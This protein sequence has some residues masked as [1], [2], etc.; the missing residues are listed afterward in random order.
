MPQV[1]VTGAAGYVGSI[2]VQALKKSG[3]DILGIDNLARGHR[4]AIDEDMTF[5]RVN[6]GDSDAIDRIMQQSPIDAVVHLA[7][8]AQAGES[9]T[10][11]GLY[12]ANNVRD[13]ITLLECM[14][15]NNVA[16]IVFSSSAAVYGVPDR[17]PITEDQA[18][19][20]I[21]PYGQSKAWMEFVL[22]SYAMS[23]DFQVV[24]LRYF[25]AAGAV[26]P[27][28]EDHRPETHL[29]P[30]AIRVA[31]EMDTELAI[32]GDDYPTPDGTAV[33]DYVHVADIAR[34]HVQCLEALGQLPLLAYN[35]GTGR[36]YSVKEVV[37]MVE[38]VALTSVP[39]RMEPRRPGDP[40][41]L[42][43]DAT[44]LQTD[45]GWQPELSGLDQIVKDAFRWHRD[46]ERG[47][48]GA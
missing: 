23:H 7:G 25:N 43:A 36:G 1:M 4:A 27:L 10:D 13:G 19:A 21:N 37:D 39:T 31:L 6:A 33:R 46:H 11:P 12:Y 42:V 15:R 22:E 16:S 48:P 14:R 45:V 32:F 40:P 17:S 38:R 28:G 26:G 34:A 35:I 3:Y 8:Y 41:E 18:R 5:Y 24:S 20:P 9:V 2:V 44:A 30:N 29:I 47:Y